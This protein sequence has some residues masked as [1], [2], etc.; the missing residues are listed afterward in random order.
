[1]IRQKL[2]RQLIFVGLIFIITGCTALATPTA[3]PTLIPPTATLPPPTD[4]PIP[5]TATML[6]PTETPL[7]TDNPSIFGTI[8][9]RIT[10]LDG[11]VAGAEITLKSFQDEACVKL[12]ESTGGLS[13]EEKKQLDTCSKEVAQVTS[14]T[15]GKY[16]FPNISP[17]WYSLSIFWKLKGTSE[18]YVNL[19]DDE[20]VVVALNLNGEY[21]VLAIQKA[22]FRFSAEE[23]MTIDLNLSK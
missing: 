13:E 12:A 14:N 3:L 19:L 2:L 16:E 21:S 18:D 5:P 15:D 1:M 10:D 23:P 11:P 17:G 6:V 22:I 20:F 7:P 4:T 8:L 9:G